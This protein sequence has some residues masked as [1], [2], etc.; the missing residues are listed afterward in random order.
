MKPII[1]VSARRSSAMV[2]LVCT[3][4]ACAGIPA[5]AASTAV[6]T[7]IKIPVVPKNVSED[8]IMTGPPVQGIEIHVTGSPELMKALPESK[9][10]YE[11]D[12]SGLGVGIHTIP[13]IP[14]Q[15][16][17]PEGISIVKLNTQS[18][19]IK[20]DKEIKKEVLVAV[21][22]D[23]EPAPGFQ[24]IAT[25]AKPGKV[26]LRGPQ[27]T[28][29]GIEKIS[30]NPIDLAGMSDSFKKETT[31]NLAENVAVIFPLDPILVE[32][33][34]EEKVITKTFQDLEVLGRNTDY[35][36]SITPPLI[37]I[38]VKGPINV[39]NSLEASAEFKIYVD[40]ESLKPGVY[41]RRA[42]I[43][44]PVTTALVGVNPEIF[45]VKIN[46]K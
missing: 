34:I 32:I 25:S 19:T 8:M 20:I 44:L 30:T 21:A 42:T 27:N 2:M 36:F 18:I 9:L 23:G 40:L 1:P 38:E 46:R 6:D 16:R 3:L 7:S 24:I 14:E 28:L 41:V 13:I 17:L 33:S 11:L 10:K 26:V 35:A 22:V 31:L 29:D 45:T 37:T 12:L 39:V 43:S 5:W 15:I 4:F